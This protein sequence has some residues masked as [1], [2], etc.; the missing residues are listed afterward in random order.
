MTSRLCA[1]VLAICC[2]SGTAHATASTCL[3]LGDGTA[4]ATSCILQGLCKSNVC[5]PSKLQPNGTSCISENRCT[6]DDVCMDGACTNGTPITCP[7]DGC[8]IGLC[9]PQFGC[10][11][12]NTCKPDMSMLDQ[13]DLAGPMDMA[14][15][16]LSAVPDD[17]GFYVD[18]A[19]T[20]LA[21]PVG[22]MCYQPP[23]AE[24]ELCG[25]ADGPFVRP[26]DGGVDAAVDASVQLDGGVGG[27]L[28][29]SRPGDCSLAPGARPD[30]TAV[31]LAALALL[32]VAL[33]RRAA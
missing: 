27:H 33:R 15:P 21:D 11:L 25:G 10:L 20:D 24:F 16:D 28:R 9:Q 5:V 18:L 6:V 7:G 12:L 13:P 19:G 2:W 29:G 8:R 22:D 14:P 30:R 32:L 23:G 3:G 17:L 4:C 31:A 26:I 1:L